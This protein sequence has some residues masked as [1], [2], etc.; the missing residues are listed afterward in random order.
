VSS[1]LMFFLL[2]Y[3]HQL[4]VVHKGFLQM[5]RPAPRGVR[6]TFDMEEVAK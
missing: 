2:K 6:I 3:Y 5:G 4:Y 1:L